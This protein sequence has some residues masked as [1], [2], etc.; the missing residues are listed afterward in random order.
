MA[1]HIIS[2]FL[3]LLLFTSKVSYGQ[4][5]Y[6]SYA[7]S[8]LASNETTKK[9]LFEVWHLFLDELT[10]SNNF[11]DARHPAF[12]WSTFLQPRLLL[13]ST[14]QLHLFSN[15]FSNKTLFVSNNHNRAR[16]YCVFLELEIA[17]GWLYECSSSKH[18]QAFDS[19]ERAVSRSY[20]LRAR[21]RPLDN[22]CHKFY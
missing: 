11:V 14:W 8:S 2:L 16:D 9:I 5:E 3:S 6:Q 18:Y 13:K 10:M 1:F 7:V 19:C 12:Q 17:A 15:A 20:D 4:S 21:R 22:Q